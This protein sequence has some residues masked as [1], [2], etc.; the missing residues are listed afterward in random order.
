MRRT[1][2]DR[3]GKNTGYVFEKRFVWTLL[4]AMAVILMGAKNDSLKIY[5]ETAGLACGFFVAVLI[6]L[7]FLPAHII[8][9]VLI[10]SVG[11]VGLK[12]WSADTVLNSFGNSPFIQAT[13]MTLVAMGCEKTPIGKRIAYNF[14]KRFGNHSIQMVFVIGIVTAIL[15]AFVSN[16]ACII[17]MSSITAELLHIAGEEPGKS[18]LGKGLML[19]VVAAAMIGGMGLMSGSVLGN[20]MC[21]TYLKEATGGKYTISYVEWAKISIPCFFLILFPMCF[22]YVKVFKIQSDEIKNITQE[23]YE[24]KLK[25]LGSVDSSEIRWIIIVTGMIVSIFMGMNASMAALLFAALAL[26]PGIGVLNPKKV[27]ADMPMGILLPI[28][29]LPLMAKLFS[30]HG[31]NLLVSDLLEPLFAKGGPYM[32][33]LLTSLCMGLLINICVNAH[34]PIIAVIITCASSIAVSLGYNPKLVM[35]P[36]M[37]TSSF[38]F[39]NGANATVLINREYGYWSKTTDPM[40]PGLIIILVAVF[41]FSTVALFWGPAMGLPLY[42]SL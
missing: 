21:I 39:A 6:L 41:V 4:A 38:F 15:S 18:R 27:W 12:L 20:T 31:L 16:V 11:G 22:I 17:M 19:L 40:L 36:A 25:E 7:I 33:M 37:F 1:I 23:Y 42:I 10:L 24:D 30:E 2:L 35:L 5:G 13:G 32:F 26:S 14:L 3:S 29:L 28:S 9:P 8:V 34:T